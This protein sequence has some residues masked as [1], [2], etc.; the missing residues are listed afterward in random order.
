MAGRCA[1]STAAAKFSE[2]RKFAAPWFALPADIT[3]DGQVKLEGTLADAGAG[4]VADLS[5]SFEGVDL[6]NEASTIVTDKLAGAVRLRMD[7]QGADSRLALEVR[8]RSGQLLF[9]PIYFDLGANPL[10]LRAERHAGRR[11]ARHRVA[12]PE[13]GRSCS[14]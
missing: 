9:T 5:A 4:L 7:P 1:A 2:L 14:T 6:T 3:G 10:Q 13:A 11:S 8:G 12:A